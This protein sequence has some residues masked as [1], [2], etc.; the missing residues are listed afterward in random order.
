[1]DLSSIPLDVLRAEVAE[2]ADVSDAVDFA[3]SLSSLCEWQHEL[4]PD[5]SDCAFLLECT[6]LKDDYPGWSERKEQ[7]L[8]QIRAEIERRA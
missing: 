3:N 4:A 8:Q 5:C 2:M 1:M 7:Y 6:G